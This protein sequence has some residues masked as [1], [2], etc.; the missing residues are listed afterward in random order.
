M[1]RVALATG[2]TRQD[3]SL[4]AAC[5]PAKDHEV[6]CIQRRASLFNTQ[7]VD[8]IYQEPHVAH[9]DFILHYGDLTD[10]SNL[11]RVIRLVQPVEATRP[12]RLEKK[13][14]R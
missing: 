7:R 6:H 10:A 8:H 13:A 5:L 4:L 11:T 1:S 12:L 2:V 9:Q 3:G 14:R